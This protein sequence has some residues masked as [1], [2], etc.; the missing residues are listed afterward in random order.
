M[1]ASVGGIVSS[2]RLFARIDS[3]LCGATRDAYFENIYPI[4][5]GDLS[6]E[7]EEIIRITSETWTSDGEGF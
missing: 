1:G 4:I 2:Q 5:L 7:G 6:R 3:D